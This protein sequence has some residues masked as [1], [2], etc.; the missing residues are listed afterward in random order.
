MPPVRLPQHGASH[1]NDW[2]D[3]PRKKRAKLHTNDCANPNG[4]GLPHT[5][6]MG[7]A[8]DRVDRPRRKRRLSWGPTGPPP[9]LARD[10]SGHRA[11]LTWELEPQAMQPDASSP[12]GS[13]ELALVRLCADPIPEVP[14]LGYPSFAVPPGAGQHSG[15]A[16]PGP[17][18]WAPRGRAPLLLA[19][20]NVQLPPH[21]TGPP[22]I[23]KLPRHSNQS[24]AGTSADSVEA[25][26]GV[27][28]CWIEEIDE[29]DDDASSPASTTAHAAGFEA[30]MDENCQRQHP[31]QNEQQPELRGDT[32]TCSWYTW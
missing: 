4:L 30:T 22:T 12:P 25:S 15:C 8:K 13:D 7:G 6:P 5:N 2:P 3:A 19:D 18:C 10:A 24:E 23:F 29:D 31:W 20:R 17:G 28:S 9:K 16:A 32:N 14:P 21:R 11:E 1:T 27:R 26:D